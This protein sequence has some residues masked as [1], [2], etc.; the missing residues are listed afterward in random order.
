MTH[1][2]NRLVRQAA[3][4]SV[5]FGIAQTAA[6]HHIRTP[7]HSGPDKGNCEHA[8]GPVGKF[9]LPARPELKTFLWLL[10]LCGRSQPFG[11]PHLGISSSPFFFSYPPPHPRPFSFLWEELHKEGHTSS[12]RPA[13]W[14]ERVFKTHL[15]FGW[16]WN[17]QAVKN[18][19]SVGW[20]E[21]RL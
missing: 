2:I 20:P 10:T 1:L 8:L 17:C 4:C 11:L 3:G 16:R 9:H 19:I 21:I 6:C 12:K 5:A 15:E 14:L 18:G 13:S 7:V